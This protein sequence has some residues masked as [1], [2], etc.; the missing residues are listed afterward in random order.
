[1]GDSNG[2]KPCPFCGGE[3][4][5]LKYSSKW[6]FFVSCKCTAVGPGAKTKE[7]AE[8]AWNTRKMER[9]QRTLWK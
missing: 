5:T 6:G 3:N 7:K 1:M 8:Q 4:V 2:L 9:E